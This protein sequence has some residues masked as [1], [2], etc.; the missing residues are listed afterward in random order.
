MHSPFNLFLPIAVGCDHAGFDYKEEVKKYLESKG[1]HTK[2]FG[3]DS[4]D[5]VDDPDFA[6]VHAVAGVGFG[7]RRWVVPA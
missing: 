6:Q 4:K 2:D 5:S 1:L 7:R 3:T